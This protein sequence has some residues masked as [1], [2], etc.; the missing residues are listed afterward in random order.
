MA[1]L[2]RIAQT[3]IRSTTASLV[4]AAPIRCQPCRKLAVAG[5]TGPVSSK[6]HLSTAS[7]LRAP[8][9]PRHPTTISATSPSKTQQ[10]S[11]ASF[12]WSSPSRVTR[13]VADN[14]AD[15][16]IQKPNRSSYDIIF[17]DQKDGDKKDRGKDDEDQL[18]YASDVLSLDIADIQPNRGPKTMPPI[19]PRVHL[20]TVPR[21]GRTVHVKANVDVARSFKLL[22][23]QVAANS[24][25]KDFRQQ[26]FH[27]R[28]GL[29]RKRLRSERWQA[30]FK[31]GFRA[32][33]ARVRELTTQGW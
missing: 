10:Q 2:G 32:T 18:D 30:R 24:M 4:R 12:N 5:V 23:M 26:R 21:T 16:N 17:G 7:S 29:K 19:A 33:C 28:P 9:E 1:E 8:N 14:I 11:Y 31:K 3:A 15:I 6:S 25:R 13:P 22:A 27:E 20:R